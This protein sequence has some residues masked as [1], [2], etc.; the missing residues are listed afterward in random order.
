MALKSQILCILRRR[1]PILNCRPMRVATASAQSAH[2]RDIFGSLPMELTSFSTLTGGTFSL[3]LPNDYKPSQEALL[4]RLPPTI[5]TEEM[6]TD[7]RKYAQRE[8]TCSQIVCLPTNASHR[9]E[10]GSS[11]AQGAHKTVSYP[12]DGRMEIVTWWMDG[13]LIQWADPH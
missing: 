2:Y 4:I 5:V 9:R 10:M 13:T 11:E 12:H 7:V 1:I 3:V 6:P 8:H